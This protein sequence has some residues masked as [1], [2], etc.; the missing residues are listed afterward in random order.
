MKHFDKMLYFH[1]K[2]VSSYCIL[3]AEEYGFSK[4]FISDVKIA[5]LLH[6]IGKISIS[7]DVLN[8]KSKLSLNEY[9]YVKKHSVIGYNLLKSMSVSKTVLDGVLYHHE[10]FDGKGY[11]EGLKGSE[12]PITGRIMGLVDAYSAM[13]MDRPYRQALTHSAALLELRKNS[14]SQF[15]PSLI[16]CFVKSFKTDKLFYVK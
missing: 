9:S 12:I 10:R 4:D 7:K 1:S 2:Q 3:L 8:K 11:P 16:D 14:G 5:G 6:D 15:D 13:V